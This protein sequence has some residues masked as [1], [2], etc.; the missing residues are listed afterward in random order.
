MSTRFRA[1]A[2]AA[3][4]AA[5]LA[6]AAPAVAAPD[7]TWTLNGTTPNS[8]VTTA[9]K[10][11]FVYTSDVSSQVPPC[12]PILFECDQTLVHVTED[13]QKLTFSTTGTPSQTFSD[14]DLH[15][16]KSDASGTM[17]TLLGE[18][19]TATLDEVVTVSTSKAKA[20]YYLVFVDWYLGRGAA[21]VKGAFTPKPVVT[22]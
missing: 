22:P 8:Q 9:E 19:V 5:T 20:G 14:V 2:L 4:G 16:Y 13:A 10:S 17:G 21:T 12:T 3:A 15:V 1:L 18:S 6:A 7:R 11:G